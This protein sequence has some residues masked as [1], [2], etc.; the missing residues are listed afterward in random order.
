MEDCEWKEQTARLTNPIYFSSA[1]LSIK[2]GEKALICFP[3]D[4]ERRKCEVFDSKTSKSSFETKYP[5]HFG[6]L[7]L[8]RGKPT[9][10]GSEYGDERNKTETLSS[11]G[12]RVLN[13]F[14]KRYLK[15]HLFI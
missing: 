1:A 4:G 8:Y 13:E 14:P 11:S 6:K 7:G 2:N 12:W 5:H 10:V 15:N 3:Y 9:T